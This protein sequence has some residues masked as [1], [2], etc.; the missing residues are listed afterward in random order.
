M[1]QD[2]KEEYLDTLTSQIRY[3]KARESVRREIEQHLDEQ[4]GEYLM[5]GM[6]PE[7]AEKEAVKQMGDPVETGISLD[8]IHRP[9]MPWG[10]LLWIGILSI[11]GLGIYMALQTRISDQTLSW[12]TILGYL[13]ILA[14]GLAAMTGI[15]FADYSRIGRYAREITVVL[16]ILLYGGLW[17]RGIQ[18][19]GAKRWI[20]LGVTIDA[21][22]AAWLFVPLYAGVLYRCRGQGYKA[23]IKAAAWMAPTL[24]LLLTMSNAS[25]L[26]VVFLAFSVIL[27]AAVWKGWFQIRRK[28]VLAVW[29]GGVLLAPAALLAFTGMESYRGQRLLAL[30][31]LGGYGPGYEAE[32]TRRL[33]ADARLVGNG[34]E[35]SALLSVPNLNEKT[36]TFGIACYGILAATA[37]LAAIVFLV[38]RFLKISLRQKNQLGMLMGIGICSLFFWEILFYVCSNTGF[39]GVELGG[40]CCPFLTFGGTQILV[41]CL[42]FGLLLSICRYQNVAGDERKKQAGLLPKPEITGATGSG[43]AR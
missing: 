30:L 1:R 9:R 4:I 41:T 35:E 5:E 19:N 20:D 12:R 31:N 36:L 8:R 18:I 43:A 28:T 2:R 15:C 26:L 34:G 33:L 25:S 6:E 42:L 27:S 17:M 14:M 40:V 24:W 23:L 29:W 3:R 7:E 38:F 10:M 11:L 13:A 21:G 37:L 32:M 39:W 16:W 22:V